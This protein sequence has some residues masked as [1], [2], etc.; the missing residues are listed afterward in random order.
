MCVSVVATGVFGTHG[1]GN[2][3]ASSAWMDGLALYRRSLGKS[4][5][6]I[7]WGLIEGVGW[8]AREE[9]EY[10]RAYGRARS[11]CVG[12]RWSYL[13]GA[14]AGGVGQSVAVED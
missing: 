10:V 1:Q 3:A 4:G 2:Y 8:V 6:S 5:V 9:S 12:R 7:D 11:W 13:G 14:M